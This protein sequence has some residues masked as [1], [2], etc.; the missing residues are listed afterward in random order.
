M[1]G[2]LNAV[3]F[4]SVIFIVMALVYAFSGGSLMITERLGR[5]WRTSGHERA[6]YQQSQQKLIVRALSGIAKISP[7][8]SDRGLEADPRMLNAGFRRSEA[9]TAFSAARFILIVALVALVYFTGF[10]KNNPLLLFVVA[11]VAGFILP[12]IWLGRRVKARQQRLR[13]ALPDA[14]DLLVIC[15]EAGLG[16]DQALLYVSQELKIAH[17]DL[18]EE[19]D[20]VNAEV[21]V[22]KTRMEALRSLATRTGV[23]DLQALVAT[24]VQTDRFGTS[25][26]QSLRVHADDL[27]T[28]RRQRAEEMSAKTTVKMV[29]PL[30]FFI[31]PALFVV[32]L[33][34][35]VITILRVLSQL[36]R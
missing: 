17:P 10:Y 24:L 2:S 30:V 23:D 35:A 21:H 22:G 25:V 26:A 14:L 8:S 4:G 31:F 12:D 11:G 33:G 16:L 27:R 13:L 28:K 6:G 15:M 3:I 34:P 7:S 1:P 29:F 36:H 20:L 9:V 19:F 18:R 5:L 32:I